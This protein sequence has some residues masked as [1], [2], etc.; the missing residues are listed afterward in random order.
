MNPPHDVYRPDVDEMEERG[1][2]EGLIKA[3][4]HEDFITRKNAA[5]ALKHLGD[6]RAVEALIRS[7]KYEDW[8]DTYIILSSVRENSAE[9]LGIIGDKRAINPLINAMLEDVD[10]NVRWNAAR[11]LGDIKDRSAVEPLIEALKDDSWSVR[12]QAVGALGRIGDE[13]AFE[14]VADAL[15]DGD[16]HVRKYAALA[17]GKIGGE[18][19]IPY[20]VKALEDGDVDVQ[21]K[22]VTALEKIGDPAVEPLINLFKDDNWHIKGKVAEILGNI[23]DER[24]V[25]PLI[26]ALVGGKK[27]MSKYVRGKVAEALGN[28]QDECAVEP[29]IKALDDKYIYVRLKA[30]DALEKIRSTG[31]FFWIMHYDNGEISF[32]YP[33]TWDVTE[34]MDETKVVKGSCANS[35]L[36]FSINR[37]EDTDDI[38]PEEFAEILRNVFLIE[39]S[40]I[41]SSKAFKTR[42]MD[43]YCLLGENPHRTSI[44]RIMIVAFKKRDLLYYIWF[45]GEPEIFDNLT[46]DMDLI[47]ESFQIQSF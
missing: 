29:L 21:W 27:C 15:E 8:Q 14:H 19:A 13:K 40:K 17:L 22:A 36:T 1:D 26:K 25:E 2:V 32:D 7:L 5:V 37:H 20:L 24:A 44:T 31:K 3:L 4:D 45:S 41:I 16:G 42:D 46:N 6:E 33:T 11:A 35:A 38:S 39:N 28:I 34:N 10:E 30:E 23:G 43:A 9:A 18:R 12:R 47:T